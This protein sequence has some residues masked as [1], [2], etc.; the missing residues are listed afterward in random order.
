MTNTVNTS[1]SASVPAPTSPKG[2]DVGYIRV[3]ST[4]QNTMR[5][6]EGIAL[7]RTFTDK[8]SGKDRQRP[9]LEACMSHLRDGDRLHVH[10]MDRLARNIVDLR[11][12]VDELTGKGVTVVFHKEALTFE[13]VREGMEGG[14]AAMA[15]LVLSIMGAIAEFERTLILERQ[16]EGIA[17]AKAEGKYRG[18]KPKLSEAQVQE[19]RQRVALGNESK[20]ALAKTYGISRETL[21]SYLGNH[22]K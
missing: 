22:G 4:D 2:Q 13:P 11:Q 19:L 3:S 21:Y 20:T 1:T 15:N 7:D 17:I 14:R 16:R 6:L 9:Q 8:A 18:S 10:S 5:Q 12:M